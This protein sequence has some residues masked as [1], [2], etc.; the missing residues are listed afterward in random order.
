MNGFKSQQHRWT[1]GSIQTCA[2]LLP[3]V[4]RARLP[5]LVKLEATAHLTSNYAYLLLF[6]LCLLL[7]PSVG[8]VSHGSWRTMLLD[9]AI[10]FSASAPAA[11]F[12]ICCQ[13]ELHPAHLAE[14]NPAPPCPAR[15]RHRPR[16]E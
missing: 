11:V 5:L 10:F 6:F 15:A 2:K 12:Y 16:R 13:R 14:G 3:T 1:K 9:I 8:G 4:W 7:H